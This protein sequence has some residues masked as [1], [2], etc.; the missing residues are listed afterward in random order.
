MPTHKCYFIQ[1]IDNNAV[2]EAIAADHKNQAADVARKEV[3]FKIRTGGDEEG[4]ICEA[5]LSGNTEAAVELCFRA[6]RHAD[7]IIIA[8]TGNFITDQQIEHIN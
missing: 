5:L 8:M 1:A 3:S 7:A 2:F 6:G 4:Q